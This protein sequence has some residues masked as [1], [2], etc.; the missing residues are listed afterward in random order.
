MSNALTQEGSAEIIL[1]IYR[2]GK[3]RE[4]GSCKCPQNSPKTAADWCQE[5]TSAGQEGGSVAVWVKML[6]F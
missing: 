3:E 5:M 2:E 1:P 6:L 4:K